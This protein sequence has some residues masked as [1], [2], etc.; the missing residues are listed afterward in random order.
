VSYKV[1]LSIAVHPLKKVY[2]SVINDLV[3]DHR[4][5]KMAT[6]LLNVGADVTLIGRRFAMSQSVSDRPYKTIRFKLLFKRG[7]LFYAFFNVRLFFYLLFAKKGILVSND[8]DTLPANFLISRIRNLSIVYDSHEYFT[9]VPELLNRGFVRRIWLKIEGSIVPRLNHIITV[10]ESIAVEY[11]RIYGKNVEVIRNLP[12]NAGKEARRPDELECGPKRVIIYQGSLNMGRGI[13][14]MIRAMQYLEQFVLQIFGDGLLKKIL[15]RLASEMIV[16]DRV[17]FMGRIPFGELKKYTRQ[18]SVG[19]SLERNIGRNY[20]Y[21]LPNKLF[22]YIHAQVPVLVSDLPEMRKIVES[23][24]VGVVSDTYEPEKLANI[25]T[26]MMDNHELRE[27][28][29]KNLRVAVKELNWENQEEKIIS[30]Y[31]SAGLSV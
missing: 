19:I 11:N 21:A 4:V 22:D 27:K 15:R 16:A 8:L 6:T 18:A 23:Y 17:Q 9:E 2:L 14:E 3:V 5:H 26:N 13:E 12:S 24:D 30:I 10:S 29:K 28:W 7:F 31:R 1:D 20:Y 25:I